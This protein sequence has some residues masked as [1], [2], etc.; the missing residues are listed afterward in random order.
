MFVSN[1]CIY[2]FTV[3]FYSLINV[4][5]KGSHLPVCLKSSPSRRGKRGQKNTVKVLRHFQ[6]L[7]RTPAE[8]LWDALQNINVRS[9]TQKPRRSR[10]GFEFYTLGCSQ[11]GFQQ[12]TWTSPAFSSFPGMWPQRSAPRGVPRPNS[13][14]D[15]FVSANPRSLRAEAARGACRLLGPTNASS[16]STVTAR[17][18]HG[19]DPSAPP[20][21][22]SRSHFQPIH[23]SHCIWTESLSFLFK[24]RTSR[25]AGGEGRRFNS[26]FRATVL[27]CP[28]DTS[29]WGA[30]WHFL[31]FPETRVELAPP[32][33][34][35]R[36]DRGEGP[37]FR[38]RGFLPRRPSIS[39]EPR[40][41]CAAP[42]FG[43]WKT[44]RSAFSCFWLR[45]SSRPGFS[46]TLPVRAAPFALPLARACADI[47]APALGPR[48]GWDYYE[49]LSGGSR[50]ADPGVVPS[51]PW[52][53]PGI[54][55]H[56][57][58]SA[59]GRPWA[60]RV[61]CPHFVARNQHLRGAWS[62]ETLLRLASQ[63]SGRSGQA[64][65]RRVAS[66]AR[67]RRRCLGAQIGCSAP[68]R[69]DVSLTGSGERGTRPGRTPRRPPPQ[70]WGPCLGRE[71]EL[72][73]DFE[74]VQSQR[75]GARRLLPQLER[76][77]GAGRRSCE[78]SERLTFLLLF[79]TLFRT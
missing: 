39:G 52:A 61:S 46:P 42:R 67:R 76:G 25:G 36:G 56:R 2:K 13:E 1:T 5:V 73:G 24:N 27:G 79:L 48:L 29:G 4:T 3:S 32:S 16:S 44:P 65:A 63:R 77:S 54:L 41:L 20:S 34:W 47:P 55:S 50:T 70:P 26:N 66:G 68:A 18:L 19:E 60:L 22:L 15:R 45:P 71:E 33:L 7:L 9:E 49:S 75:A 31:S 8:R 11:T 28:S 40:S 10:R 14:T 21:F 78:P 23:R 72:A 53:Q 74:A 30:I 17:P 6:R 38:P 12:G 58:R 37:H 51:A 35:G 59:L 69:E 57:R 62:L 64:V 43:A